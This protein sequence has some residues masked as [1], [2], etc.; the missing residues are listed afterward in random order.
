MYEA[1]V[2]NL[3]NSVQNHCREEEKEQE[4]DGKL[5]IFVLNLQS[6]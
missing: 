3:C 1:Y 2:K 4:A 6:R 5:G